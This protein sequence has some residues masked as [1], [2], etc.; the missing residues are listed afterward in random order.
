[1]VGHLRNIAAGVLILLA[2]FSTAWCL[3]WCA[4]FVRDHPEQVNL[5]ALKGLGIR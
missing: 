1:M 2:L 4:D 3:Q 5:R